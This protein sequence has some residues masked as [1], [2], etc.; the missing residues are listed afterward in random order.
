MKG[1]DLLFQS[2]TTICV[3]NPPFNPPACICN[4]LRSICKQQTIN[5]MLV[6]NNMLAREKNFLEDESDE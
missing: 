1:S 3:M 5:H 4:I 6:C 2:E